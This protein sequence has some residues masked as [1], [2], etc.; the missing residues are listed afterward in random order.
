ME[1]NF[2]TSF[3]PKKPM[4][5]ESATAPRSV[6]FFTIISLFILF[7]ILLVTGGLYFYK[8]IMAKDVVAKK[9][10]LTLAKNRFEPSKIQE[11]QVLDKRLN[12]A[13]EILSKH[14]AVTPI[15]QALQETTMKSVRFTKFSYSFGE[16]EKS[17]INVKM[18]GVTLGYS[19][20]ALQSDLFAKNK[21]FIDPVFSNLLL[22]ENGNVAFDL[23]FSV[24]P[25]FV[26][27]KVQLLTNQNDNN[28]I[29]EPAIVN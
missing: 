26:D 7:T 27:Y 17:R 15:F 5:R 3:I 18:S 29:I 1:Q 10:N 9:T 25:S 2:Q 22:N 4:V 6:N 28:E 13:N 12:A 23:N 24:N 21:N 20:L 19:F 8:G 11:L 16:D 14:I